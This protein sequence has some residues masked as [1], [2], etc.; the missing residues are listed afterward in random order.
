MKLLNLVR[1]AVLAASVL[2]FGAPMAATVDLGTT[3]MGS[4]TGLFGFSTLSPGTLASEAGVVELPAGPMGIGGFKGYSRLYLSFDLSGVSEPVTGATLRLFNGAYTSQGPG[5]TFPFA[6]L[7]HASELFNIYDVSTSYA[8]LQSAFINACACFPPTPNVAGMAAFADLGTGNVYGGYTATLSNVGM[9]VDITLSAQ[10]IADI[11]AAAGG[12]FTVG[13]AFA[14]TEFKG[15]AGQFGAPLVQQTIDLV[16]DN[17]K[18]RLILT[19][20][21]V[22]EPASALLLLAG[23]GLLSLARRR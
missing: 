7:S 9:N 16:Q 13:I 19:T 14:G 1:G 3:T 6:T 15:F 17:T 22:P 21:P 23:L 18:Q 8:S 11:N 4:V 20:T 5:P 12:G 10:A 2:G